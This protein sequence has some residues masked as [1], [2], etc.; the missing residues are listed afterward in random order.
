MSR[1]MERGSAAGTRESMK[2]EGVEAAVAPS[3]SR[4]RQIED[5]IIGLFVLG[6]LGICMVNVVLRNIGAGGVLQFSDEVQVYLMV[7]GIFLSLSLVCGEGRHIKVDTF[8]N[9]LPPRV[10]ALLLR[11]GDLLGAAFSLL[12]VVYGAMITYEAYDFGDLSS[13]SLRFPLWIYMAALPAG[14]LLMAIRYAMRF[15]G[16]PAGKARGAA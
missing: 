7:W 12:L 4:L 15:T 8:V 10:Q 16:V 13:T 9:A 2:D 14:A 11:G 1:N 6:A 3:P 5:G